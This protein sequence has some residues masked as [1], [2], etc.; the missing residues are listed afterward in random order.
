MPFIRSATSWTVPFTSE[1]IGST[2][3]YAA[4]ARVFATEA[5][6]PLSFTMASAYASWC[7]LVQVQG[8]AEPLQEVAERGL[9]R[10]VARAFSEAPMKP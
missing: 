5:S 2:L 3:L 7:V 1:V 8:R 10:R 9:L 6:A 4:E